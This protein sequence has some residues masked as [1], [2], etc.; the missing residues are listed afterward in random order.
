MASVS[1]YS[2]A[3][4]YY[5]RSIHFFIFTSY[6]HSCHTNKLKFTLTDFTILSTKDEKKANNDKQLVSTS[7]HLL[8]SITQQATV[9]VVS[10][11]TR[12]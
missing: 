6:P 3:V 11:D 7:N 1:Q 2:M 8:Y 5:L 4:Q 12:Y 9:K 10:C